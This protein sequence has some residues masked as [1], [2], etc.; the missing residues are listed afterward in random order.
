MSPF[1]SVFASLLSRSTPDEPSWRVREFR[2]RKP[3]VPRDA[4]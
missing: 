3:A 4:C 1:G 2:E